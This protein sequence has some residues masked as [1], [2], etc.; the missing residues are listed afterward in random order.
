MR[1]ADSAV[2]RLCAAVAALTPQSP[3]TALARIRGDSSRGGS[4]ALCGG[5]AANTLTVV[6]SDNGPWRQW[7]AFGGSGGTFRGGKFE[8]TEGGL[9]VFAVFHWPGRIFTRRDGGCPAA[10]AAPAAALNGG[11]GVGGGGSGALGALLQRLAGKGSSD[12]E[13]GSSGAADG[14]E[15]VVR[16]AATQRGAAA[17]GV[18]ASG[19]RRTAALASLMDLFPTL[20]HL[21][22]APLPEAFKAGRGGL[23]R[24]KA[25]LG[26]CNEC[27]P[28]LCVMPCTSAIG[29]P[30]E[31][32]K[33]LAPS[34][35]PPLPR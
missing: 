6:T 31:L 19:G 21:G 22:R 1:Q 35:P 20:L 29:A 18:D 5:A 4:T 34:A 3:T 14:S 24:A 9:R 11:E 26:I 15:A 7:G 12:G 16:R 32:S 13:S 10:A 25:V 8:A 2:A 27:H 23:A 33:G 30:W 28:P 17:A